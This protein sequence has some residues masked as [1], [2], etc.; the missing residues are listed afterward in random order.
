MAKMIILGQMSKVLYKPR[1]VQ[2]AIEVCRLGVGD[3]FTRADYYI[4]EESNLLGS[5]LTSRNICES[6][7][8]FTL[9]ISPSNGAGGASETGLRRNWIRRDKSCGRGL[10]DVNRVAVGAYSQLC[11]F[12]LLRAWR[13]S[14]D[15]VDHIA[16]GGWVKWAW[17]RG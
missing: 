11:P 7:N 5:T 13:R 8:L 9:R 3:C 12:S 10:V 15:F 14:I 2:L 6:C 4:F 16:T 17:K 1:L